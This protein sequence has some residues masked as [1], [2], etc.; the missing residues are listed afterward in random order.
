MIVKEADELTSNKS[1]RSVIPWQWASWA[2]FFFN[3]IVM[4]PESPVL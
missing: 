4:H 2:H 3:L 1:I